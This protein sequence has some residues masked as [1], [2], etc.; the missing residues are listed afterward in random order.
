MSDAKSDFFAEYNQE[1]TAADLIQLEKA[2]KLIRQAFHELSFR[3]AHRPT[4]EQLRLA[5][6][7]IAAEQD[8]FKLRERAAEKSSYAI[9]KKLGIE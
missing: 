8:A 3:K 9:N 6:S 4:V 5:L 7:C 1:A 2:E